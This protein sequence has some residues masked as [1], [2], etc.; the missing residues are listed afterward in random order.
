MS[1]QSFPVPY[2][3][4]ITLSHAADPQEHDRKFFHIIPQQVY[5]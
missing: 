1:G 3:K 4:C 2:T 5:S